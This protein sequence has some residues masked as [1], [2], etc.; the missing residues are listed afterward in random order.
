MPSFLGSIFG[1]AVAEN[2][3]NV[4]ASS[5]ISVINSASQSCVVSANNIQNA[6]I[7]GNSGTTINVTLDWKQSLHVDATCY[8]AVVFN[9]D[10]QQTLSQQAT[11][12][13]KAIAQQF[14]IGDADSRNVMNATAALGD[15]IGNS[16]SQKCATYGSQIQSVSI[17]GNT[18]SNIILAANWDQQSNIVQNCVQ[19][20]S[21]VTA[22]KNQLTQAISQS[23]SSTVENWLAGIFG[24]IAMVIMGGGLVIFMIF[25]IMSM[26]KKKEEGKE[27]PGKTNAKTEAAL[28][29]LGSGK[30]PSVGTTGTPGIGGSKVAALVG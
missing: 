19:N 22:A 16:F 9:T 7:S 28:A 13:A 17:N 8:Q 26:G 20:D 30:G 14:Q 6:T 12:L 18:N 2:V 11:Q 23:A 27:T 5:F 10:V 29:A 15:A 1:G 21:A 4:S 3:A 24:A 25:I